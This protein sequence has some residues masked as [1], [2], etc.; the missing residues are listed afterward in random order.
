MKKILHQDDYVLLKDGEP[1]E[2]LDVIY[3]H[4]SVIDLFNNGFRLED[5]EAFVSMTE[6]SLQQQEQYLEFINNQ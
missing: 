6:L 1:V 5:D 4:S 3:H 2:A